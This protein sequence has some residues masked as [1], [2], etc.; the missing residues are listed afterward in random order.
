VQPWLDL[1]GKYHW[2]LVVTVWFMLFLYREL[3]PWLKK[4]ADD[5]ETERRER[6]AVQREQISK[7]TSV[8]ESTVRVNES[9][10]NEVRANGE[11]MD[12]LA[13]AFKE[14]RIVWFK[15]TSKDQ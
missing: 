6:E 5:R 8:M 7:L 12:Q 13:D 10:S 2:A 14:L 1:F 3:W 15:R 4:R 11:K 9:L